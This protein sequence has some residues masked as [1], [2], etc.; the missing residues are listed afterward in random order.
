MSDDIGCVMKTW[1]VLHAATGNIVTVEGDSPDDAVTLAA[2]EHGYDPS[3]SYQIGEPEIGGDG[4]QVYVW[5][6]GGVRL[7]IR[8]GFSSYS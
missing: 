5:S 3:E 6:A 8:Q 4:Q 2:V 1:H 7:I